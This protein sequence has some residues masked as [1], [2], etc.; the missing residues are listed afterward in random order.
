MHKLI[1]KEKYSSV[2]IIILFKFKPLMK[3]K[4]KNTISNMKINQT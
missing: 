1:A 4:R 3:I 2:K